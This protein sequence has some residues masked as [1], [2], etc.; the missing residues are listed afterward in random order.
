M[1]KARAH[2]FISGRVQGVFFRAWTEDEAV[3]RDLTGWVRNLADGRVE[4]VFEGDKDKVEEMVRLCWRGP[5][6]AH[7]TIVEVIW[8]PC[9]GEFSDFRIVYGRF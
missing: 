4:A 8:E 3:K 2:V 9:K 7:I 1:E 6:G 5:P